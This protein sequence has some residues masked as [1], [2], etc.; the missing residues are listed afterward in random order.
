MEAAALV[1]GWDFATVAIVVP[2]TCAAVATDDEVAAVAYF[3]SDGSCSQ[4]RSLGFTQ[5]PGAVNDDWHRAV[6]A[7]GMVVS[8]SVLPGVKSR[9]GQYRVIGKAV[10][11]FRA[12]W[13]LYGLAKDKRTHAS[14]WGLPH[15][16][17]ALFL[18]RFWACDGHVSKQG[19]ECTLASEKLIDDLRFL[20]TRLGVRFRK[21]Y[22][23]ASYVKDG[24]RHEFDAW[25]I[26]AYGAAAL[27]FL[28]EVGNVLGKVDQCQALRARLE[29]TQ[30]NTNH[31]VVPIGRA[32]LQEICDELDMPKRGGIRRPGTPRSDVRRF[33]GATGGQHVSRE[34]FVKFCK[35]YHYTGKYAH[36]ATT[37][38]A[39]ERVVSVEDIGVHDVYDLTVPGTHNFVANGIVVH[40]TLVDLLSALAFAE[41]GIKLCVL[42]I[43]PGLVGQLIND[44]EYI[45]QHFKMPQIVF[46]GHTYLN[47]CE[48]MS[49]RVILERGAPVIHVVKYSLLSRPEATDWI[50]NHLKPEAIIA[51]ECHRLR[52]TTRSG[53]GRVDR[54]MEDHPSTRFAAWSGSMTSKSLKDYDHLAKWA[55]RGGSPLPTNDDD[56]A[57]WCRAIDPSDNPANPGPLMQLC[58]PGEKLIDGFRRRVLET[59]GVVSTSA[60]AVDAELELNER[61]APPIPPNVKAALRMVRG[62]VPGQSGPQRPDGDELVDA[63]SINRVM[64]QVACGFYYKWIYPRCEFPR[65]NQLVLDWLEYRK[66]WFCEVRAK[67]KN[68]EEH[69]DSPRLVQNAAERFYGDR[70]ANRGM[71]VWKSKCWPSWRDNRNSIYVET[72][73][74]RIDSYLARDAADWALEHRGI[75]WY[76]QGA[77]GA[78]V[79]ELSG[80]P[81]FGGGKPAKLALLGDPQRQIA[82]EDGTRSVICS[83]DALGTGTNGLQHR[84]SENLIANPMS[85]P[86]GW[87]QTLGRTHRIG[88]KAPVVRNW[89]YRHTPEL[90][91]LVDSA[92]RNA[93]YV[94]G[95]LGGSQKIV[96]ALK[97]E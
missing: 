65:D 20:G 91:K 60:P 19:V 83:I 39:W 84:F 73:T 8:A 29:S 59:I 81:M 28:D 86:D 77:F 48:K 51:D 68:P 15:R 66:N 64:M 96:G 76:D 57:D 38:V 47:T 92:L 21:Q 26:T 43:P 50:E 62:L 2:D 5:M 9:A 16:Q 37:D 33:F 23:P 31:D 61:R 46:H 80:L 78:W 34:R 67:L 70:P 40:N 72:E 11:P 75:V 13:D 18:N 93:F 89:F 88:Q 58:A 22:K 82:G 44:Y 36:L 42:L 52:D 56:T 10:R 90:R 24:V 55:L 6:R 69:L 35:T 87:E 71:P 14:I 85:A 79:A 25:R 94:E 54:Y 7:C 97:I 41:T 12:K 17:V 49:Q 74:V 95:S 27:K 63:L 4:D 45:G 53:A 32:E 1:P 30:R 3:C